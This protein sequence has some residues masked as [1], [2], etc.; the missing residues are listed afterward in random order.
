MR[1]VNRKFDMNMGKIQITQIGIDNYMLFTNNGE[2]ELCKICQTYPNSNFVDII[3]MGN[4][5]TIEKVNHFTCLI[6]IEASKEIIELFG[7]L[8]KNRLNEPKIFGYPENEVFDLVYRD[9]IN[10]MVVKIYDYYYLLHNNTKTIGKT[11]FPL[12]VHHLQNMKANVG[13]DCVV[14]EISLICLLK[15]K[16]LKESIN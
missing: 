5:Q 12:C 13:D 16:L 3:C 11:Y 1:V 7:F 6:P 8:V 10:R 9:K 2:K 15:D 14:N 4:N